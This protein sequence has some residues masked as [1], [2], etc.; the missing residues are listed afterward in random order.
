MIG[1]RQADGSFYEIM[2]DAHGAR[3][4]LVLSAARTGQHGARIDLYRSLD[5]TIENAA[6][7]GTLTLDD[8]DGLGFQDIEFHVDLDEDGQLEASVALPGQPPR[9]LSVDLTPFREPRSDAA[10]LADPTLEDTDFDTL[11]F[12][13]VEE[14][15]TLPDPIRSDAEILADPALDDSDLDTLPD[16]ETLEDAEFGAGPLD[17]SLEPLELDLEPMEF[18]AE[19]LEP[20]DE[21]AEDEPLTPY[22]PD[23]PPEAP[24][25]AE[26][27][28]LADLD[29]GFGSDPAPAADNAAEDWE[30]ISLDDLESMEFMDTGDEISAPPARPAPAASTGADDPFRMDDDQP[31]DLGDLDS[32]L[33]DL[34]DLDDEEP[35][36]P[37]ASRATHDDFDQDFVGLEE[38]EDPA[39][40]EPAPIPSA[41]VKAAKEPKAAKGPK[42][43]NR[44]EGAIPGGL[45]RTALFLSLSA[46]SLL[47]L[48]ILVL[49]FL[50]MVKA[51][52]PPVIQPE[53]QRWKP[54][55]GLAVSAVQPAVADLG[56]PGAPTFRAATVLEVPEALKAS[57]V[58]LTLTP[59]DTAADAGRRF[60]PPARIE[61]NLLSW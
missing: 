61:G 20:E 48:L 44:D 22:V 57:R 9:T 26:S 49:L 54:V 18:D 33:S 6:P 13:E 14:D 25:A 11:D 56:S 19:P 55:A 12:P 35:S 23:L 3:K 1:I 43:S 46:L 2:D 29:A 51:P 17:E 42:P 53:V 58:T 50:N 8:P 28:D 34:P 37:K 21:P 5:G 41:P 38:L 47:V 32:D 39:P 16:L 10:I 24:L 27:F 36:P 30:K 60:G 7:L 40:W 52:Q 15:E 59:G 45:D 31:L 4:R